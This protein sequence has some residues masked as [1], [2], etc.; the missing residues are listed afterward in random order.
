MNNHVDPGD[1]EEDAR[2]CGEHPAVEPLDVEG[3]GDADGEAHVGG[4][5]A[6]EVDDDRAPDRE[7][8]VVRKVRGT[9]DSPKLE[10]P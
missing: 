7:A 1:I 5:R 10:S 8:C 2:R 4:H 3:Q 9:G 6:D